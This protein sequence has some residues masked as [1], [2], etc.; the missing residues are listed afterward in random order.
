M[1]AKPYPYLQDILR[2]QGAVPRAE[3]LLP[4]GWGKHEFAIQ[5]FEK[6]THPIV[7]ARLRHFSQYKLM[8]R[9]ACIPHVQAFVDELH[10]A[11][12]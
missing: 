1:G 6:D 7:L 8:T 3:K 10:A 9:A 12:R 5:V 4:T 2:R 11:A